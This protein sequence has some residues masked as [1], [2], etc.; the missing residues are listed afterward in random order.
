MD[1]ETS[2]IV[3]NGSWI[4]ESI[5]NNAILYCRV[6]KDLISSKT[7]KPSS[8]AFYN[9]P[10]KGDNLSSD[11]NKYTT[12]YQSRTLISQQYRFGTQEFKNPLDF[13]IVQFKVQ[14]I[15]DKVEGQIVEH[16]PVYNNPKILGTPNNRA[17]AIIIGNKGNKN[18]PEIRLKFVEICE[19]AIAPE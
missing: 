3:L 9:T 6:H 17:H 8:S 12:P 18:D 13:F 14:D 11:W 7:G 5:P 2:K 16:N 4:S 10:R 19:W 15:H 1:D